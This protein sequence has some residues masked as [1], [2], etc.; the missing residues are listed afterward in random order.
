MDGSG[1]DVASWD[2]RITGNSTASA[3]HRAR[4]ASVESTNTLTGDDVNDA[5]PV[6][7]FRRRIISETP[8][9]NGD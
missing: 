4:T 3:A 9:S 1:S 6:R 2:G 7:R 5:Q 8:S